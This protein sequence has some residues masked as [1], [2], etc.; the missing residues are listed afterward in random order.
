MSDCDTSQA[1]DGGPKP[2]LFVFPYDWRKDNGQNADLLWEY[3]RCVREFYPDSDVDIVAHSM[4]SLLSR[5]YILDNPDDHYVNALITIGGPFL[6]APKL[7]YVLESGDFLDP[8]ISM[9]PTV[10]STFKHLTHSFTGAHQ[11]LP[12]RKY[13]ELAGEVAAPPYWS[14]TTAT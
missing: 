11:L 4:G 2:N 7:L 12:S 5:R 10:N 14:R 1:D 3:I 13:F 6:G 9:L 8:P